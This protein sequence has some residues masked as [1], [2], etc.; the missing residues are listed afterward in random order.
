MAGAHQKNW[1]ILKMPQCVE[2]MLAGRFVC[3]GQVSIFEQ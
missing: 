1:G 3:L 2:L